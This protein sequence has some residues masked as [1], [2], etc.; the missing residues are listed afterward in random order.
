MFVRLMSSRLV[1]AAATFTFSA[2]GVFNTMEAR[3]EV[4]LKISALGWFRLA[5]LYGCLEGRIINTARKLQTHVP[6]SV[7]E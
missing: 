3:Y 2:A 1:A 4:R 7:P 6:L 5:Y